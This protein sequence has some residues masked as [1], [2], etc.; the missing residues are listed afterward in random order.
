MF[1]RKARKE[2]KK[3]IENL[4]SEVNN[5]KPLYIPQFSTIKSPETPPEI[6][7]DFIFIGNTRNIYRESVKYAIKSGLDVKVIGSGW[8]KYISEKYILKN[9]VSNSELGSAYALGRVVLCD[10]WDDM[11]KFGFVSNRIYD[12][13][14]I[15]KP[16]LTDYA[17]DIESDLTDKERKY[18][19]T[20]NSFEDFKVKSKD[21]LRFSNTMLDSSN[22]LVSECAYKGLDMIADHLKRMLTSQ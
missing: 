15:G 14:S 5:T 8:D 17:R 2:F 16:I 4:R 19:F 9:L 6:L 3:K 11:K 1:K 21:V 7:C 13:L 10:H 12:C 18:V 22:T 20:Y